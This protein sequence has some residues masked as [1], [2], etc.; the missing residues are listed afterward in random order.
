MLGIWSVKS[1]VTRM[2]KKALS[3]TGLG[4]GAPRVPP[5]PPV[6]G[7]KKRPGD[8]SGLDAAM[9]RQVSA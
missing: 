3:T 5:P 9:S 1:F 2:E 6:C 4:A 8:W 7:H